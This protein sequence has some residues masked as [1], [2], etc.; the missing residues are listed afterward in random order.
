MAR[1]S[2]PPTKKAAAKRARGAPPSRARV[3]RLA[4]A[5]SAKEAARKLKAL[6]DA[7]SWDARIGETVHY[8]AGQTHASW[9]GGGLV[10]LSYLDY[11]VKS[12]SGQVIDHYGQYVTVMPMP[13]DWQLTLQVRKSAIRPTLTPD[14]RAYKL[15]RRHLT[16]TQRKQ[17]NET[18]SFNVRGGTSKCLYRINAHARS[19]NITRGN[20]RYCAYV[21]RYICDLPTAD[22]VLAQKLAIECNER[23]FLKTAC[24][25]LMY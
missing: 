21:S 16:P 7:R 15:L 13:C 6:L 10:S 17:L 5:R 18:G 20:R 1:R 24:A 23:A 2:A 8:P 11:A 14:D 9:V 25:S 4:R 12:T 19:G 3:L 22:H